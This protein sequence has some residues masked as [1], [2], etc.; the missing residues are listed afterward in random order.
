MSAVI[1]NVDTSLTNIPTINIGKQGENKATQVVFDVSEMID[2]Y[3]SGTAVVVVQRRGDLHPYELDN[4]SQS[5]DKVTWTVSNV[6]TAVYGTGRVQ[7][8]WTI[9]DEVAKT[10]TYAFFVEEALGD[11]TDAPYM[12]DDGWISEKIGDLDS[13]TT[14]DK[15]NL[16]EAIN[17]V[18]DNTDT[19]TTAIGT[20]A[21]LTT[22]EK[23]NLVGAI[24]EVDAD[25]SDVKEDFEALESEVSTLSDAVTLSTYN[26]D[27]VP[28]LFRPSG[29]GKYIGGIEKDTIVGGTVAWNQLVPTTASRATVNGVTITNNGD[30]SWTFNGTAT[31]DGN[32][33][34]GSLP[35]TKGHKYYVTG[36]KTPLRLGFAGLHI[37]DVGGGIWSDSLDYSSLSFRADFGGGAV[38]NGVTIYPQAYDLTLMFG[39]TIADYVYGLG[40]ANGI[41]KLK[42]WGFFTKDYYTYDS[43]SLKSVE[44]LDS[45]DMVGFNQWDED[46]EVG[47]LRD[48]LPVSSDNQIRSKNFCKCLGNTS[49][50]LRSSKTDGGNQNVYYVAINWY[51]SDKNFISSVFCNNMTVT[52]P[53]NATYFKIVTNSSTVVYGTT[54]NHDICINLSSLRNGQYEPYEK[55]SY[56]LDSDLTLRGIF[57]LDSSNQLYYD[58]DIYKADGSVTR[59]YGTRAYQSGD[60]S[61]TDAITDGTNTVYKLSTTTTETAEPYQ[62][63]QL[64]D[65]YG[66]EEYVTTGVVPVGHDTDYYLDAD[67]VLTPPSTAGTYTFKVTVASDGSKSYSWV[68]D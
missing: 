30:G 16:V 62:N 42:S 17:E 44:S 14:T 26:N 36:A 61:L 39:S 56:P 67:S 57:K 64:V 18:D 12:P 9:N 53:E 68:S 40:S 32:Y 10:V 52:S 58:G 27:K 24:N 47:S 38:F 3:G 4:T 34:F 45:H 23:S 1:I 25:V 66:T 60:E 59:K 8:F 41:A 65:K 35:V 22:T 29:G 55:H 48:G 5:G 50:Y 33:L 2:T 21:N 51:D 15:D 54:Y 7:L 43:G 28:Y 63:P 37:D 13:L 19:N 11:P 49:Y 6:D 20:L 46:W 31:A